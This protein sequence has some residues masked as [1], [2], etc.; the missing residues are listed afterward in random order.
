ME[1]KN[2]YVSDLDKADNIKKIVLDIV[3]IASTTLLHSSLTP[4]QKK[5]LLDKFK[6][7]V[8]DFIGFI[9]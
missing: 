6:D 5:D 3:K 4:E 7:E 1:L 9:E 8:K 2:K